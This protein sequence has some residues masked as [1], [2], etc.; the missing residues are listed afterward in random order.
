MF[1]F[2]TSTEQALYLSHTDIGT[3]TGQALVPKRKHKQTIKNNK[4]GNK[5][6]NLNFKNPKNENEPHGTVPY[7]DNLRTSSDKNYDEP[8]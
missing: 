7:Q 3:S 6:E 4:N 8:L 1:I 2:G 5:L